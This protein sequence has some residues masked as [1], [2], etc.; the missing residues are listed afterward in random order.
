MSYMVLGNVSGCLVLHN[1]YIV[2]GVSFG[3]KWE[4]VHD[5]ED[6]IMRNKYIIKSIRSTLEEVSDVGDLNYVELSWDV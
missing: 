4:W 3:I 1:I 6:T 5:V 2:H